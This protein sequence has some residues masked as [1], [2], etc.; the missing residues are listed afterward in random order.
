MAVT[1]EHTAVVLT[2]CLCKY[3]MLKS[4]WLSEPFAVLSVPRS[5]Q[6]PK[7]ALPPAKEVLQG[8]A[9]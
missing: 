3:L 8:L 7:Q 6:L 9:I 2:G 4:L 5:A 1:P